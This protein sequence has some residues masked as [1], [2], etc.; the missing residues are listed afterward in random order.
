MIQGDLLKLVAVFAVVLCV[1]WIA[2][3]QVFGA[4]YKAKFDVL[5]EIENSAALFPI[6]TDEYEHLKANRRYIF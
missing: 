4:L 1:V 5:K 2:H 6:F 3:M